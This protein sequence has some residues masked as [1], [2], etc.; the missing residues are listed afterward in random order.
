MYKSLILHW[1]RYFLTERFT[2]IEPPNPSIGLSSKTMK[3]SVGFVILK[4]QPASLHHS[5]GR[6]ANDKKWQFPNHA[7]IFSF[8]CQVCFL[9]LVEGIID[10]L[11]RLFLFL[12]S[13]AI[14]IFQLLERCLPWD[15]NLCTNDHSCCFEIALQR[16]SN[17]LLI[18]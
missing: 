7:H 8:V 17:M 1:N 11:Q 9:D 16:G 10:F 3:S 4:Q 15:C 14:C 13:V 18:Q 6:C 12:S 5:L 2:V